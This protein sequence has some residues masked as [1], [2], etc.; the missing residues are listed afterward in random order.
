MPAT[1]RFYMKSFYEY[2]KTESSQLKLECTYSW[3]KHIMI[4]GKVEITKQVERLLTSSYDYQSAFWVGSLSAYP[5][6]NFNS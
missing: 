1:F 2:V 3:N 5:T 6:V 4:S